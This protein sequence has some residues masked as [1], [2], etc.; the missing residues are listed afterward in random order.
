MID[1][2][3]DRRRIKG[4]FRMS[5]SNDTIVGVAMDWQQ[6]GYVANYQPCLEA[7][8]DVDSVNPL[9]MIKKLGE[10]PFFTISLKSNEW[11]HSGMIA[12][13]IKNTMCLEMSFSRMHIWKNV[14]IQK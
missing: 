1:A 6:G 11:F 2:L 3:Q 8:T 9:N 13:L 12:W 7:N 14:A 10:H 4:V 5:L